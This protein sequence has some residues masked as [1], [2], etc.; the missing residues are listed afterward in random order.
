MSR[1]NYSLLPIDV[2]NDN[3]SNTDDD[4]GDDV[5]SGTM[6]PPPLPPPPRSAPPAQQLSSNTM[7]GLEAIL[8]SQVEA[9]L[10]PFV[11]SGTVDRVTLKRKPVPSGTTYLPAESIPVDTNNNSHNQQQIYDRLPPL[12]P[13]PVPP[14]TDLAA[15]GPAY[16]ALSAPVELVDD[17]SSLPVAVRVSES[18]AL[19]ALQLGAVLLLFFGEHGRPMALASGFT[20]LLYAQAFASYIA[21]NAILLLF[22]LQLAQRNASRDVRHRQ[23]CRVIRRRALA[24]YAPLYVVALLFG[25]ASF[26]ALPFGTGNVFEALFAAVCTLF[27]LQAWIPWFAETVPSLW[28]VSSLA[29]AVALFPFW[30]HLVRKGQVNLGGVVLFGIAIVCF[31]L[32]CLPGAI[33][34]V[35]AG[36]ASDFTWFGDQKDIVFVGLRSFP[37]LCLSTVIA[38]ALC[39]TA[40]D[41]LRRTTSFVWH[42]VPSVLV[43][44]VVAIMFVTPPAHALTTTRTD[45]YDA[46]LLYALSPL[47]AAHIC[48]VGANKGAFALLCRSKWAARVGRVAPALFIF[49]PLAYIRDV[50]LRHGGAFDVNEFVYFFG[51]LVIVSG[52]AALWTECLSE[53][54][55]RSMRRRL[56]GAAAAAGSESGASDAAA[57]SNEES[58]LLG[59]GDKASQSNRSVH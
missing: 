49:S 56:L 10:A 38:G 50:V 30:I 17:D 25:A 26:F 43:A 20:P 53:R 35:A 29:F 3:N 52:L 14:R 23:V 8:S 46:V 55:A 45:G 1:T 16:E 24:R 19:D 31:I 44:A 42:I 21:V 54:C 34:W 51:A 5:D 2:D 36:G 41:S 39:S 15:R 18:E 59:G 28:L 22:G 13:P 7:T 58:P 32:A 6:T 48:L 47:L 27:A 33:Y 12:G 57:A 9:N 4:D 11:V 37:L 40:V